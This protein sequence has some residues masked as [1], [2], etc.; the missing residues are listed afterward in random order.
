MGSEMCIRDSSI[1]LLFGT[2]LL[3]R[4]LVNIFGS[5]YIQAVTPLFI[6]IIARFLGLITNI[7]SATILSLDKVD[8]NFRIPLRGLFRSKIFKL[9]IY[10]YLSLLVQFILLVA[11]FP[12]YGLVGVA[13]FVLIASIILLIITIF[14]NAISAYIQ[15][16]KWGWKIRR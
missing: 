5:K 14:V 3:S 13:I 2:L 6:L 9:T 8:A 12:I 1:P 10:E 7:A 11:L 15:E 16:K 4:P